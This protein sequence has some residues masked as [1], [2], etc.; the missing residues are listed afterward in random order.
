MGMQPCDSSHG[1][2]VTWNRELGVLL[3]K[4]AWGRE[5][6]RLQIQWF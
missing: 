6:V 5:H 4:P 1:L 2:F 3:S